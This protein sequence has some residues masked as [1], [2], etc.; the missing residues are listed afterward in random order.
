MSKLIH[1]L[2][3]EIPPEELITWNGLNVHE[4]KAWN[5]EKSGDIFL[6]ENL[7]A[8]EVVSEVY[9]KKINHLVQKNAKR[10]NTDLKVAKDLVVERQKYF[11]PEFSFI[12]SEKKL[13]VPF[14]GRGDKPLLKDKVSLF[15]EEASNTS[16]SESA[17]TIFEEMFMNAVIDAPREASRQNIPD[18]GKGFEFFLSASADSLQISCTD[19]FGS[20]ETNKLLA[21]MHE[22][23]EKG[24]GEVI[25]LQGTGGA[26]IGCVILFENS[27]CLIIGVHPGHQTKVTSILPLGVSN[28]QREKMQ[29][30]LHW[31]HI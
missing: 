26:G 27:L 12:E 20:L 14:S 25:N 8:N 15:I 28:R 3:S 9:S 16:V 18:P 21:R 22:V 23:Y 5:E 13:L 30:S 10:F 19:Y 7:A 6:T 1:P 31:F 24:A 17:Q 11:L 29:K 4:L 2:L